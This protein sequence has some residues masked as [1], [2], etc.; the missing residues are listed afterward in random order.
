MPADFHQGLLGGGSPMKRRVIA[1]GFTMAVFLLCAGAAGS[2]FAQPGK[3]TTKGGGEDLLKLAM[4]EAFKKSLG[5]GG[6]LIATTSDLVIDPLVN[7]STTTGTTKD[8]MDAW[9]RAMGQAGVT[10]AWP[11]L[12]LIV[13]GGKITVGA[14][15]YG[16]EELIAA[17]QDQQ[18]QAVLF[19]KGSG[20]FLERLNNVMADHPFI[21][22]NALKAAGVT[23]ENLGD[24]IKTE[25]EL[26]RY[27]S[28]YRAQ[29]KDLFGETNAAQVDTANW[30][31]LLKIWRLQRA[32]TVLPEM[33]E[34]LDQAMDQALKKAKGGSDSSVETGG[35]VPPTVTATPEL[36]PNGVHLVLESVTTSP[37]DLMKLDRVWRQAN[38]PRGGSSGS[39]LYELDG[40]NAKYS[41]SVPE[42]LD[43]TPRPATIEGSSKAVKNGFGHDTRLS[44]SISMDGDAAFE[45]AAPAIKGIAESNGSAANEK[46]SVMK[47][48]SL[49]PGTRATIRISVQYAFSVTYR[50]VL[51]GT[52]K[53]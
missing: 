38:A 4:L 19:G 46:A 6:E 32:A 29:I 48:P 11:P 14:A 37:P 49:T 1:Q 26:K 51:A 3:G 50:Y 53:Q 20:G 40:S 39:A 23:A 25:D 9:I 13:A 22:M 12:G 28:I 36:P 2:A 42:F 5:P 16:T 45:R 35:S 31:R 18:N 17:L 34:R 33:T 7:A 8:K 41:W 44:F 52:P 15:V 27:W 30:P 47:A 24:R 43:A 10:A 21:E